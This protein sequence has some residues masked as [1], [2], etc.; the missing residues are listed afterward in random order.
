LAWQKTMCKGL[1]H[2]SSK[3]WKDTLFSFDDSSYIEK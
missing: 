1:R 2:L 3:S